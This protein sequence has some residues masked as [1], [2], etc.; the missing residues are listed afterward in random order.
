MGQKTDVTRH[1]NNKVRPRVPR[2]F[3]CL[4]GGTSISV[5]GWFTWIHQKSKP[6]DSVDVGGPAPT[7]YEEIKYYV[8]FKMATFGEWGMRDR[9]DET[10]ADAHERR[11]Y[12]WS[13]DAIEKVKAQ[14]WD[15]TEVVA[16]KSEV[17]DLYWGN[18][19]DSAIHLYGKTGR[20]VA[21]MQGVMPEAGDVV[22]FLVYDPPYVAR[23][24]V[25][26]DASPFN[27][28]H[29]TKLEAQKYWSD[30]VTSNTGGPKPTP[31]P[32][33]VPRTDREIKEAK[34]EQ[35]RPDQE[36]GRGGASDPGPFRS[37]SEFLYHHAHDRRERQGHHPAPYSTRL[38]P[39]IP[40]GETWTCGMEGRNFAKG[41]ALQKR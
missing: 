23:E 9:L 8:N 12:G 29:R 38:L 24:K 4:I 14:G 33:P 2:E 11:Y 40:G 32:A 39:F 5:N 25:D 7:T 36:T 6:N 13:D 20:I 35:E 26:W 17:H 10:T 19:V 41:F 22:T 15:Q 27:F 30:S 1:L 37:R 28:N 21:P 3:I 16:D 34:E 31:A 18:F